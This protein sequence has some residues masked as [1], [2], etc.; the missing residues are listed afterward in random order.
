[1]SYFRCLLLYCIAVSGWSLFYDHFLT[2]FIVSFYYI[3]TFWV[4]FRVV[5]IRRTAAPTLAPTCCLAP[6]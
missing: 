4:L 5:L 1:M 2:S 3:Q 6:G